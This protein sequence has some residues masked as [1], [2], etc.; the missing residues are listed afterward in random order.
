MELFD[1]KRS[2]LGVTIDRAFAASKNRF[3]ILDHKPLHPFVT[4]VNFVFKCF[5][6]HNWILC[7]DEFLPDEIDVLLGDNENGHGEETHDLGSATIWSGLDK[8]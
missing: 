2:I 3:K 1:L 6:L 5:I 7:V 4:K 8:Y